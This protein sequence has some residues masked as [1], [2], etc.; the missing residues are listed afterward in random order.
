MP[1]NPRPCDPAVLASEVFD[2][3]REVL[4]T[5]EASR[6]AL[7]DVLAVSGSSLIARGGESL[8]AAMSARAALERVE[9]LLARLG[10]R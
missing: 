5:L 10:K 9:A 4:L 8:A 2:L 1:D 6:D 3:G 7:R